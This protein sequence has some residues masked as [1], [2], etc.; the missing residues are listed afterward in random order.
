MADKEQF[1]SI[2][3]MPSGKCTDENTAMYKCAR[4][5]GYVGYIGLVVIAATT[6]YVVVVVG[7][8]TTIMIMIMIM[9]P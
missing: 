1:G 9:I 6:T 5:P 8:I 2:Y 3:M 7:M 4:K